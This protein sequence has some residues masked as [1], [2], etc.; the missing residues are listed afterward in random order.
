MKILGGAVEETGLEPCRDLLLNRLVEAGMDGAGA[1]EVSAAWRR[2]ED[3]LGAGSECGVRAI[4]FYDEGFP[5][6]LRKMPDPPAVLFVKGDEK[7]LHAE[8]GLAVVGTRE[9]TGFG[10]K[11]AHRS[12]R[13]AVE[14]GYAIV[15][16]LAHGCDT[17]AHE[18]CAEARG[19]GVVVLAHGLDRVYPAGNRDLAERLLGGGG[20][21]TSE[22]PVG[23][24]PARAAFADR[25]R[26][27]SGLSDGILVIETDV[28]GGTMHTVRF[29]GA[30]GRP[31]ACIE[32]GDRFRG[33]KKVR[34][35]RM[36]IDERRAEPIANGEALLTFLADLKSAGK[37]FAGGEEERSGAELQASFAF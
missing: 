7:G 33:E 21:L 17:H 1:D 28:K 4:A 14:A 26:I 22:Y 5:A 24:A 20:C 32:H 6:R 16:G 30:Q 29:A 18:G 35:N 15:S 10:R 8:K 34:G 31:V 27:Q 11:V 37:A 2:S 3:E 9:P 19:I 12:A 25:D 36:L 13:T 23:T